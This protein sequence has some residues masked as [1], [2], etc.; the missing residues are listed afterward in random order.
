MAI[1]NNGASDNIV[2]Y[3]KAAA[4]REAMA[5][6]TICT[7]EENSFQIRFNIWQRKNGL[8]NQPLTIE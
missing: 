1:I 7:E 3:V 5:P 2:K 6:S 8:E 4:I